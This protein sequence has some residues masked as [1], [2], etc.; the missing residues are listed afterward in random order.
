MP[1]EFLEQLPRLIQPGRR[2]AQRLFDARKGRN[3]E[4]A[5]LKELIT[6][7]ETSVSMH[8]SECSRILCG[9]PASA[10]AALL[11]EHV[12]DAPVDIV[13]AIVDVPPV[14]L[15]GAGQD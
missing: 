3:R 9:D 7:V 8:G 15:G 2:V 11:A 1:A 4:R 12:G 6:P 13:A 10:L 5:V 14:A